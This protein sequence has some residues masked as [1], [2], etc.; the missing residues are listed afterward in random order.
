MVTHTAWLVSDSG[1]G[2]AAEA[3]TVPSLEKNVLKYTDPATGAQQAFSFGN[4]FAQYTTKEAVY[5]ALFSDLVVAA[6][7]AG[8]HFCAV[9]AGDQSEDERM[10]LLLGKVPLMDKRTSFTD[11]LAMRAAREVF[12]LAASQQMSVK[13]S[14]SCL[15]ENGAAE[16]DLLKNLR[17]DGP[18]PPVVGDP[19]Y[20]NA[21][22]LLAPTLADFIWAVNRVLQSPSFMRV[23]A[24]LSLLLS[25]TVHDP[26]SGR[27]TTMSFLDLTPAHLGAY[28]VI[29]NIDRWKR[30]GAPDPGV[31][32]MITY[33]IRTSAVV[34]ALVTH[35]ASAGPLTDVLLKQ[36]TALASGGRAMSPALPAG[37]AQARFNEHHGTGRLSPENPYAPVNAGG[38][39][40]PV[41]PSAHLTPSTTPAAHYTAGASSPQ[42]VSTTP[43]SSPAGLRQQSAYADNVAASTAIIGAAAQSAASAFE[44]SRLRRQLSQVE[45]ENSRLRS[46]VAE[47]EGQLDASFSAARQVES[48]NTRLDG[49]TAEAG[50]I[51]HDLQTKLE[52][53][54]ALFQNESLA[55][56]TDYARE[57][58]EQAITHAAEV[59]DI[60]NSARKQV[61]EA[62]AR[63]DALE[64]VAKQ[65]EM[66]RDEADTFVRSKEAELRTRDVEIERLRSRI[67]DLQ[68]QGDEI[69]TRE[70]T[71]QENDRELEYERE[72]LEAEFSGRLRMRE[73]QLLRQYEAQLASEHAANRRAAQDFEVETE[74]LTRQMEAKEAEL[75]REIEHLNENLGV[76]AAQLEQKSAEIGRLKASIPEVRREEARRTQQECELRFEATLS[77]AEERR[78]VAQQQLTDIT[79]R[80]EEEAAN[81]HSEYEMQLN[82]AATQ[83]D[84]Q[85]AIIQQLQEECAAMEQR[86]TEELESVR[87]VLQAERIANEEQ[88]LKQ[89]EEAAL[90]EAELTSETSRVR[91]ELATAHADALKAT[92]LAEARELEIQGLNT[93]ANEME[94]VRSR[95]A[96]LE[97]LIR[98]S[99]QYGKAQQM[100]REIETCMEIMEALRIRLIPS[101]CTDWYRLG[102]LKDLKEHLV[103]KAE[104]MMVR[105]RGCETQ[106]REQR[107]REVA[108]VG[109][110]ENAI[111]KMN[112]HARHAA[113]LEARHN[114]MDSELTVLRAENA[115]FKRDTV[116]MQRMIESMAALLVS[117]SDGE[118]VLNPGW[119]P[120]MEMELWMTNALRQLKMERDRFRD[121]DHDN[122][123]MLQEL[124]VKYAQLQAEN[125]VVN[126]NVKDMTNQIIGCSFDTPG[127]ARRLVEGPSVGYRHTVVDAGQ[128]SVAG[129]LRLDPASQPGSPRWPFSSQPADPSVPHE[130]YSQRLDPGPR[131]ASPGL[132]AA[133]KATP[134]AP[135][136][137]SRPRMLSPFVPANQANGSLRE[138]IERL[139]ASPSILPAPVPAQPAPPVPSVLP[140]AVPANPT[141]PSGPAASYRT[142]PILHRP[143]MLPPTPYP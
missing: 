104:E 2:G 69:M 110:H 17:R 132:E 105:I 130:Y 127:S 73:N 115:R 109:E 34:A 40:P 24:S 114:D 11:G 106:E 128:P 85:A 5:K 58:E 20:I 70:L 66:E 103:M 30:S 72:R 49:Q 39:V 23:S 100:R 117:G 19:T 62:Q 46:A 93:L 89:V 55:A 16:V 77:E 133:A 108:L 21:K 15:K 94:E 135:A 38:S 22:Y 41:P 90:T 31:P 83:V 63:L 50:L 136:A 76:Q 51:I 87:S 10:E 125:D 56:Q 37:T 25:I 140:A 13:F 80:L 71:A 8:T 142:H 60:E 99:Q 139:R 88:Q 65:M 111:Q 33:P 84:E 47:L 68:Q 141:N 82:D 81:R 75:A 143:M 57:L 118:P 101:W 54:E 121:S 78:D 1:D 95:N 96:E 122:G 9:T 137:G 119:V 74:S 126:Q 14:L 44:V 27:D 98:E 91:A 42:V 116:E 6:V 79:A 134:A 59:Q 123:H 120:S 3:F 53:Q 92:R 48:V 12:E 124:L 18:E 67:R 61:G 131:A 36:A 7:S 113:I 52:A 138:S 32:E 64:R 97:R 107:V 43:M 26:L 102:R 29:E 86:Y 35:P 45:L 129:P 112:E 28:G 4:V